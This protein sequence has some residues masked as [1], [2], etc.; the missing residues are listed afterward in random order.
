MWGYEATAD[1]LPQD[2]I[3]IKTFI[4]AAMFDCYVPADGTKANWPEK[5]ES[6]ILKAPVDTTLTLTNG[7]KTAAGY[8]FEAT[9]YGS[10]VKIGDRF[11]RYNGAGTLVQPWD[12]ATGD[13]PATVYHNAYNLPWYVI[14]MAGKPSIIGMG[15]LAALPDPDAELSIRTEPAF[16]FD[17][18]GNREPFTVRRNTFRQSAFFDIGDPRFYHIDQASVLATFGIG[19]RFHVYP[20]PD[21]VLTFDLRANVIPDDLADGDTPE[22]PG[23]AVDNILLP[24]AREKLV[25]NSAGRRFTGNAQLIMAAAE[26]ARMQLKSM[27]RTQRDVAGGVRLKRGW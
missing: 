23:R 12:G 14:E 11:Y 19:N 1:L 7:A 16:D 3:D 18:K 17:S 10:F 13:Y 5:Y 25:E 27:R 8:A 2:L 6:G 21:R 9:Y 15:V 20:L 22:L 26:R 4:A 24:L